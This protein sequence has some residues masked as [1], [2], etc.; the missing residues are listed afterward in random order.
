MPINP[1]GAQPPRSTSV[2][3]PNTTG[4]NT[5]TSGQVQ[6]G[7]PSK[8]L[9]PLP[10]VH[11]LDPSDLTV[12]TLQ[13][14]M[15]DQFEYVRRATLASR[16]NPFTAPS[17]SRGNVSNA[18]PASPGFILAPHALGR[19]YTS[20]SVVRS[21]GAPFVGSEIPSGSVGYV[22]VVGGGGSASG[23]KDYTSPPQVLVAGG[24]GTGV[25]GQASIENGKVVSIMLSSHGQGHTG[26]PNVTLI[27]GGGKGASAKVVMPPP[28]NP[29]THSLHVSYSS[30]TYDISHTGD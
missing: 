21:Q 30:G 17:L 20:A 23:G 4:A 27:G 3:T 18:T 28:F 6:G 29:N 2:L 15:L 11:A 26:T 5:R 7:Q 12:E 1:I 9:H 16:Q 25:V 14:Q 8:E 19:P 10:P 24:G 13:K 22:Q